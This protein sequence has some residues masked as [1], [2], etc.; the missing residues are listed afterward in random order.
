MIY[1]DV[2]VIYYYLTAHPEFGERAK[3]HLEELNDLCTSALTVWILYVLTKLRNISEI[4]ED[5]GVMILPLTQ[6]VLKFAI[7]FEKLSFE[8]A[9]HYA[10]MKLNG[11]NKILSDDRDFDKVDV[12]RIF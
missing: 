6:D 11:I 10:T 3:R 5:I 12:E 7:E 4:L 1:V 9:I 8:D 2:N